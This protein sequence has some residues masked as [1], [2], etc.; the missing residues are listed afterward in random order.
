MR[1]GLLFCY[2]KDLRP[3]PL[4]VPS[5]NLIF[6]V[7]IRVRNCLSGVL[8]AYRTQGKITVSVVYAF[9]KAVS[10]KI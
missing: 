2:I 9:L 4:E 7:Y 3:V 6:S 5:N 8:Y 1:F 10:S